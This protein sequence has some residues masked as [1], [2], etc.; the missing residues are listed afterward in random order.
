MASAATKRDLVDCIE[1]TV[2]TDV[3]R[4]IGAL[5]IAARGGLWQAASAIAAASWCRVG[6]ITGFF[7]PLGSPPA[8]ETDGPIGAAL[9]ARGLG[10]IGIPCR[11]ATD[12]PCRNACAVALTAA[13]AADVPVDAV[14]IGAS[15]EPLVKSWR[16]A[17]VTHAISIERCGR[18]ADGTRRNMR[19]QDI[20]AHTASLDE[21]F[22]A[23]PWETIAVGDGGNEIGMG[24]LPQA[25][26]AAHVEHGATIACVTAAQHLIVAGVS[27]WGAYALI[28]AL[29]VICEDWRDRLLGCL[30]EGLD[31]LILET[32]LRDGPAVD[33]VSRLQA[34]TIDNLGLAIHHEKSRTVRAL[35]LGKHA[36][37]GHG[38]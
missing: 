18:S 4:N 15:L 3:G 8:A 37:C 29:A 1:A 11:L 16:A 33:G 6:L 10:E 24:A 21:L 32:T 9:L 20:S 12:E 27:H 28:G 30:D 38:V 2:Q 5:C 31:T 17:G 34:P 36:L 19:G 7:V 25:L 14:A 23:G 13:G 26:I 35:V 22:A